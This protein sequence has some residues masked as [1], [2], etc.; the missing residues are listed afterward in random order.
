MAIKLTILG[1]T[2][3]ANDEVLDATDLTPTLDQLYEKTN[4]H[5]T[6]TDATEY[7]TT[8]SSW[9]DAT[10]FTISAEN[11]FL[12]SIHFIANC[13]SS[14][15][16]SSGRINCRLK[17]SGSTLGT[18]YLHRELFQQTIAG[19]SF[20]QPVVSTTDDGLFYFES[21]SNTYHGPFGCNA[22]A[23]LVLADSTTTITVQYK[24]TDAGT[25]YVKDVDVKV[26]YCQ[27]YTTG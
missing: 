23:N 10:S 21:T 13:K 11:G 18:Y 5:K 15:N 24:A 3:W 4:Y 16:G 25:Q 17:I 1:G 20:Y 7:S 19:G 22:A 14:I 6:F 27:E 8:S 26:S 9:T 2:D 12:R